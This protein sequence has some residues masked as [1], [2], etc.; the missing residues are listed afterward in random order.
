MKEA[1]PYRVLIVDDE[2]AARR[3]V[4]QLLERYDDF[5]VVGECATGEEMVASVECEMPELVFL[6]I[7]MPGLDG[8]G[9]LAKVRDRDSPLVIFVT[10]YDRYAVRAFEA[11]AIDY[12]LKP[13]SAERFRR[14]CDHAIEQLDRRRRAEDDGYSQ[15]LVELLRDLATRDVE[16]AGAPHRPE[17]FRFLVRKGRNR[18]VVLPADT[19]LWAEARKDYVRLHTPDGAYLIR[20]TMANVERRLDRSDFVRIHRSAIVRTDAIAEMR[21]LGDGRLEVALT[22]G[23]RLAVSASGRRLLEEKLGHSE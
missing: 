1:G 4:A 6:D 23:S 8:F 19:V 16:A 21:T 7:R 12:I 14:A 18:V 2:P 13:Y 3:G 22:D 9:A 10:G 17:P 5:E 11:H 20:D 15:R